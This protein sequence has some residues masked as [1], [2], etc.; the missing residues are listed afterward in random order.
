MTMPDVARPLRWTLTA[1]RRP[2]G[3][4]SAGI[5]WR[6]TVQQVVKDLEDL[7]RSTER[8]FLAIGEKLFEFRLAARRVASDMAA[9]TELISGEQGR[10]ASRALT[11]MLEYSRT[12]DARIEQSAQALGQVHDLSCR[13]RLAFAGLHNTVSVFRTLCTLTQIET[14]RLGRNGADFG[15][16]A[17]EVRPLSESIQSSGEGVLEASSRLDRGIQMAMRSGSELRAR[18]LKELPALIAAVI[19]SLQ[20]LD[21]RRQRAAELSA[22]QA[23]QY[24]AVCGAVDDVVKSV[25]FH[26]ITRQQIEHVAHALSQLC[27]AGKSGRGNPSSYPPGARAVL[28]LESS[29]LS[30]AAGIFASSLES[31][32]RDLESIAVRVQNMAEGSRTLMGI[33]ADDQDSF[34]LRLEGHFTA[35]LKML[36]TCTATQAEMGSTAANLA[37]TIG[38]M[39]ESVAE[40][41]RTEI[42]IRRIATNAT[43]RATHI[44]AAGNALNVIAEVMQG[45]ALDSNTNTE[46]VGGALDAMGGAANC[47]SGARG[48]SASGADLGT[49]DVT[50]E[51]RH[52]VA[53]LHSSSESS[54][55]RVNQ[56]A[57]LGARLAGD[58]GAVRGGLTAGP[59]FAQVVN[60]ARGELDRLGAQAGGGSR[61]GTDT[62][63]SHQLAGL[64]KHYTMQ[65]ERD[66]HESMTTGSA[67]PAAPAPVEAPRVALEDGDLGDNV[68]LF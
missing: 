31:M 9:L 55:S 29:Q 42:R 2:F 68:E 63:P 66:V 43:I 1:L 67:P 4:G 39:R 54:F 52:A 59:L 53:E 45:L 12:M 41:R 6:T 15:D 37:E 18:Q 60:R 3:S 61:A 19:E 46:D 28:A 49:G 16:L 51:M 7:N 35:I 62:A 26:D 48:Q 13:I 56:I 32:E 24:D 20:S 25:Q 10:N 33:S 38:G 50:G 8:D 40:I 57:A 27:S 23:A 17:A 65:R 21:E 30:G 36:G 64:A 47:V 44:G 58:A 14:S 5:G 22:R 34:F 11:R